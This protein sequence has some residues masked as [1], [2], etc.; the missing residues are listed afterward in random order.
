MILVFLDRPAL[1]YAIAAAWAR[2]FFML[3]GLDVPIFPL[4]L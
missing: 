3:F 1:L 2:A 4:C